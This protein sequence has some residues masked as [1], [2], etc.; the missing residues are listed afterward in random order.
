MELFGPFGRRKE[1]HHAESLYSAIVERARNP[2][3]YQKYGVPDSVEGRFDMIAIHAFL[4][5]WRLKAD[6]RETEALAQALFDRM[7]VD[8]DENLREMGVGD[9][10]VGTRVKGMAKAFYGRTAAY[11]AGL[12]EGQ[13]ELTLALRRNLYRAGEPK[14]EIAEAMARYVQGQADFL[15][16]LEFESLLS[17]RDPFAPI[18][19]E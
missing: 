6:R 14:P 9:L 3:F 4:I 10:S 13:K 16:E 2:L 11:E 12:K 8:M 17:D 15:K 18:P 19:A 7:F 5:L 1:T